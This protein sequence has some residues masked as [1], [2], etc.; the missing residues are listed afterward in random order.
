MV[1]VAN[2]FDD[3]R[4]NIYFLNVCFVTF[5]KLFVDFIEHPQ[6]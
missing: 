1:L 6:G 4:V 3:I 2:V 5:P